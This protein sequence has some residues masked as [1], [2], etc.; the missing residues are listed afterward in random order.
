MEIESLCMKTECEI[1]FRHSFSEGSLQWK[2][3]P[4]F[5]FF[6]NLSIAAIIQSPST[7]NCVTDSDLDT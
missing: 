2:D 1:S 6:T 5:F 3:Q 4:I 7:K